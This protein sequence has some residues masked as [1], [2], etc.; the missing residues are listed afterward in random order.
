MRSFLCAICSAS[1]GVSG[2]DSDGEVRKKKNKKEKKDKKSKKDKKEK[3]KKR[4]MED[5]DEPKK[6]RKKRRTRGDGDEA[7]GSD[8][9]KEKQVFVGG[10]SEDEEDAINSG[11][12]FDTVCLSCHPSL[13]RRRR[14]VD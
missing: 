7:P 6:S 10:D 1:G 9:E 11:N 8:A 12:V 13:P 4:D 5:K 14:R 3:R 2:S